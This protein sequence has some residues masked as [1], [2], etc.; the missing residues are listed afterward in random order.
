M[1]NNVPSTIRINFWCS[2]KVFIFQFCDIFPYLT[3]V[4]ATL[5]QV[6]LTYLMKAT[7]FNVSFECL[8]KLLELLYFQLYKHFNYTNNAHIKLLDEK[9]ENISQNILI[10]MDIH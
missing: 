7:Y 4:F 8:F 6:S 9:I 10:E 1:N 3:I 2:A 5:S